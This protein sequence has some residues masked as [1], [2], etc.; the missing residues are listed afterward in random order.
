MHTPGPWRYTERRD[1]YSGSPTYSILAGDYVWLADVLAAAT[2]EGT[3]NARLIAAA[4]ELLS[5]LIGMLD[6]FEQRLF[7]AA[8]GRCA[9]AREAIAKATG[10]QTDGTRH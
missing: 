9:A 1:P 6:M 3:D 5:A 4:P 2:H 7:G 8:V 10:A